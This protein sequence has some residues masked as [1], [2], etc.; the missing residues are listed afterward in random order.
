MS[1]K[2]RERAPE[3]AP[4]TPENHELGHSPVEEQVGEEE[5]SGAPTQ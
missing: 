3:E 5:E 1:A 2:E 4:E